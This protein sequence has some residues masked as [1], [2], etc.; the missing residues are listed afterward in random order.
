M[1]KRNVLLIISDQHRQ[2]A[3]GCRGNGIVRTPHMDRLFSRGVQ[4]D[5][6]LSPAPLCGPARCSIFSGLY[7]HQAVGILQPEAL[8]ARDELECGVETDMMLNT[9]SLREPDHL[10][11]PFK[12]DGY[13]TAYAGKWHLGNDILPDWFENCCGEDNKQYCDW[14]EKEGLPPTGWSLKD[15]EIRSER[16]PPMSIPRTKAS[17]V[18][19]EQYNDAW[20]ADLALNYMRERPKD[21]PFF[22]SCGFNGPHPPFMIPEPWYSMYDPETIP[23]PANFHPGKGEPACKGNSFYRQLWKDHGEDWAAWKKSMAVYYGFVSYID[24]QI[25]RLIAELEEQGALDDTLI[26]YTSDHGEMLGSHGLWHKMQA[27]EES[28]RVPLLFSAPWLPQ[29]RHSQAGASLLD[30]PSTILSQS[31]YPV[32]DV[33]EGEDLSPA[34]ADPEAEAPVR[35]LFSEQKPLGRFHK[36]SDWRMITDNRYKLIWNRDDIFELYDLQSDP[37]ELV[38]L[39]G[40]EE[41]LPIEA[42]LKRRLETWMENTGDDLIRDYRGGAS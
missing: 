26:I 34:L 32:P 8:G 6:A 16:I 33:Y 42:E 28:L 24:H 15:S 37:S 38:N 29:G 25:G 10:T 2:E 13:Y 17:P 23:E 5:R 30:I 22:I 36:E 40:E 18:T 14:L 19:G 7:P 27:Y 4:F 31:G 3:M 11:R 1:K 21:V 20:I 39:A 12:E 35:Y 9:T 41:I